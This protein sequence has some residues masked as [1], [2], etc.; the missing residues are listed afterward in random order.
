MS[1]LPLPVNEELTFNKIRYSNT[2][3]GNSGYSCLVNLKWDGKMKDDAISVEY[4][5][6]AGNK[7]KFFIAGIL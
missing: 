4:F 1:G 5:D 7:T 3:E 2:K 6:K